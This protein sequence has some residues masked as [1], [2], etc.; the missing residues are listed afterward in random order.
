MHIFDY[1]YKETKELIFKEAGAHWC[2]EGLKMDVHG[3]TYAGYMKWQGGDDAGWRPENN[4]LEGLAGIGLAIISHLEPEQME[5][6]QC[7]LIG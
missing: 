3:E 7:L 5:W 6:N 4:V 2:D 1:L